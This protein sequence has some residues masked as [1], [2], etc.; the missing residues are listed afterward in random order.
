MSRGE[1]IEE[2]KLGVCGDILVELTRVVPSTTI[3]V[4]K[5]FKERGLTTVR[6]G[7]PYPVMALL[8]VQER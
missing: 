6:F 2:D 3:F 4:I 5:G 7:R 8:A 1:L